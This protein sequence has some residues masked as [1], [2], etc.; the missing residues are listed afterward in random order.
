MYSNWNCDK[1]KRDRALRPQKGHLV[2]RPDPLP[3]R[4]AG[5]GLPSKSWQACTEHVIISST[6]GLMT[7]ARKYLIGVFRAHKWEL[8]CEFGQTL[9]HS[10]SG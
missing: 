9:F 6:V 10:V 7:F 2:S 1:E 8:F 3:N 4:Y 5:R